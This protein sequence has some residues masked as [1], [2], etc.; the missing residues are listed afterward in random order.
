MSDKAVLIG[1]DGKPVVSDRYA[2][3]PECG[4]P[5]DQRVPSGGFGETWLVCPCGYEFERKLKCQKP[6]L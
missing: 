3:C 1:P 4:R 2:P 6:I 5:A